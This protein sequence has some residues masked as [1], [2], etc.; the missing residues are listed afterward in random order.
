MKISLLLRII[1]IL[2]FSFL[3][4]FFY[5][6]FEKK[7][8]EFENVD[9]TSLE[10]DYNNLNVIN[11]VNYVSKDSRGNEYILNALEGQIDLSN[12]KTIFLTEVS[13]IV[14]FNDKSEINIISD[15]GKYNI[16]NYDTIFSKNV[17]ITFMGHKIRGNY[18]DFSLNRNSM[19]ISKEVIYTYRNKTLKADVVEINIETKDTKI[20]MYEKN[21]K[22]NIK[23]EN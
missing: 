11:D 21:E 3:I 13:A 16:D 19:I 23:S 9:K 6:K 4:L 2:F 15:F 17:I 7:N 22:V 18:L 20:F 14:N 8:N 10:N 12:N 1:T 5:L